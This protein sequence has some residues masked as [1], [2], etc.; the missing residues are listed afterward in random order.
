ME[1]FDFKRAEKPLYSGRSGSW[2][3]IEVPK[4]QYLAV[5]GQGAP[6]NAAYRD[7]MQRL[8]PVAYAIKFQA[9]A[10]GRDFVVAPQNSQ[11]WAEDPTAFVEDRREEWQW[12]AMIRMPDWVDQAV[13][14]AAMAAK[15]VA[16][17]TLYSVEEG[18]CYQCLHIGPYADEAPILAKLHDEVMPAAGMAFNGPHHEIYLSD[19]RRAAPDKLRTILRQPVRPE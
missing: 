16:G 15:S 18:L 10:D 8:Y 6:G 13:V 5:I 19:P 9:K 17:V 14:D 3:L 2:D 11:W 4:A 12:R 1:K 7:A